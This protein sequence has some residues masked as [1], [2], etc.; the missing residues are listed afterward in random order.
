MND[1]TLHSKIKDYRVSFENDLGFLKKLQQVQ[2]HIVI[3]DKNVLNLYLTLLSESF[4]G[5]EIIPFDAVEE[6]KTIESC[7]SLY[8]QIIK[9]ASKKNMA[10]ISIGGGIT[11][12][13]TGFVSS[14]LYRGVK[15][16]YIPTTFLAQT[17]SCIGSKTS[18]NFKSYKNLV[19]TFYPP[20]QI[21][22]NTKFLNTLSE[23]DFYSGI[24]ETIKLQLMKEDGS[25]DIR[26]IKAVIDR[27]VLKDDFLTDLIRDNMRVKIS[28]MENDEFDQGRR[29]LLNYGHCFGHALE[30]ASD[31]HIPHGIA[32]TIGILF[33]NII[34][35]RRNMLTQEYLHDLATGLII[36]CI[37]LK[38]DHAY[39][40]DS[41]LLESMKKDKKNIGKLLTVIIP[42]KNLQIIKVDNITDQEVQ[43]GN[44]MLMKMLF[45]E[46][47]TH[48]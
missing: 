19:G 41:L 8:E 3:A 36:P 7:L 48:V 47:G 21:F 29:N 22:I 23:L 46:E 2:P 10:I 43:E 28:Y 18:L 26:R 45:A 35:H 24:G 40:D 20:E 9:K 31:Y 32:V 37:P 1:L 17:D 15:W 27:A 13:V 11:Q 44:H 25:K 6:N 14:T 39:F 42:D 30:T 38:L 34:A 33:A 5:D 4:P 16:I 12:D